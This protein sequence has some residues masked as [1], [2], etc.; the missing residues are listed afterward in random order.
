MDINV[1]KPPAHQPTLLNELQ[2]FI[3]LGHFPR[4]KRFQQLQY[5]SSIFKIAAGQFADDKRMAEDFPI[6]EQSLKPREVIAKMRHPDRS[7]HE[8]HS[9]IFLDLLLGI[10]RRAFSVPPSRASLRLLSRAINALSPSRTS[11]VFS[12]ILVRAEALS[13]SSLSIL[14]VV[15]ICIY[16]YYICISVKLLSSSVTLEDD[17]TWGDF[18]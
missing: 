13:K 11:E 12:S 17:A 1:A 7:V 16:M 5:L 14:I 18:S 15:L 6:P 10:E 3:M 8:N 4:G 9:Y 2:D